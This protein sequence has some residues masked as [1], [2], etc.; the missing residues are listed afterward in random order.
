MSTDKPSDRSHSRPLEGLRVLEIGQYIAAPYCAL[1]LADQGAEVIKLERPGRGDPRRS[2]DPLVADEH[3]S[4]SGGFLSYNRNKK[5]LTLDLSSQEGREI[6]LR[7]LPTI[8]IIVENLRPGAMDRLG[9]GYE[10]LRQVNPRLVYCAISGYGRLASHRGKYADRPAFDTA[11]QATGGLMSVTGQRD[12][13]PLPTVTGF[14]DVYSGVQAAFGVLAAVQGRSR[15][16]HGSFVDVS[17]Y[18]AVASLLERE[19]MLYE[20][21]GE[22]RVRGVDRYAPLGSMETSDG[23][24]AL[25]IPTDEMWRRMCVA[26]SR[27]DLYRHPDLSSVTL[28]AENFERLIR[29]AAEDWTR[30]RTRA[31]VVQH[32]S[33]A[34]LPAGE[35]QTVDELYQCE[36]LDARSMFLT[37]RDP[38]AGE[39]R[40]IR[41]PTLIS[42]A[43]PTATASAP[44]LGA[45]T[46][47]VLRELAGASPEEI[48][49]WQRAGVV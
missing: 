23:Y 29:P 47:W 34:G 37:V 41:T 48:H 8:D 27:E 25:I 40:M 35:V 46:D 28:R 49:S 30:S 1:M 39:R 9:L 13:P 7:L 38:H 26:I 36:H 18:D 21:T 6:Y 16:G 44:Q 11:V 32:F 4:L 15:T 10:T 5:S 14:A 2:Y 20:F 45:D 43:A 22:K 24:V 33:A 31:D 17:M 19:L 12:G 3:G 42:D